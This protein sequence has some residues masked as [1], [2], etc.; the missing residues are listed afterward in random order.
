MAR[1]SSF[2][3]IVNQSLKAMAREAARAERAAERERKALM[4]EYAKQE[5]LNNRINKMESACS[6]SGKLQSLNVNFLSLKK[7]FALSHKLLNIKFVESSDKEILCDVINDL[8][9]GDRIKAINCLKNETN[10]TYNEI[11]LFVSIVENNIYKFIKE[12]ED[13]WF[14]DNFGEYEFLPPLSLFDLDSDVDYDTAKSEVEITCIPTGDTETISGKDPLVV[15][16]RI[17]TSVERLNKKWIQQFNKYHLD[18][19][20]TIISNIKEAQMNL[21]KYITTN[22]VDTFDYES[23]KDKSYF[24]SKLPQIRKPKLELIDLTNLTNGLLAADENKPTEEKTEF[25]FWEKLLCSVGLKDKMEKRRNQRFSI[26]L[27][28]WDNYRDKIIKEIESKKATNEE[29]KQK[30]DILQNEYENYLNNVQK[31]NEEFIEKQKIY[32]KTI[33]E[34]VDNFQNKEATELEYYYKNS[35]MLSSY[36]IIWEKDVDLKYDASNK[37]I[38]VDY[39]LPLLSEIYDI[40]KITY[41]VS[42]DEYTVVLA[43]EKQLKQ[44]YNNILYQICLRTIYEL[45]TIDSEI[46]GINK[47]TFNGNVTDIDKATG[48]KQTTCILSL[49][50]DADSFGNIELDNIDYYAC[51]KKLNGISEKDLTTM[52]P[53]IL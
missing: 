27:S 25:F 42:K 44:D 12:N 53:I 41:S 38:T 46:N 48:K 43:K 19:E 23:L 14:E 40:E 34:R 20:N 1:R 50:T 18:R 52:T 3:S 30:Y 29:I 47:I 2:G 21:L 45:F 6:F 32:N 17:N 39:K 24:V 10:L 7:E 49:T 31:E 51:F 11:V 36:P 4:R 33:D 5:K 9:V 22:P 35:V 15:K 8:K 16:K 26:A 28:K 13:C 37:C